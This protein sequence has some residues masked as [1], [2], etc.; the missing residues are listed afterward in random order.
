MSN[1]PDERRQAYLDALGR[2]LESWSAR[3]EALEALAADADPVSKAEFEERI[4]EL[5]TCLDAARDG[6]AQ[7]AA[8]DE[9]AWAQHRSAL[10]QACSEVED[11]YSDFERTLARA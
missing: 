10:D 5:W 8:A 7:C 1:E 11:A 9:A 6:H 4:D 2:R 3:I